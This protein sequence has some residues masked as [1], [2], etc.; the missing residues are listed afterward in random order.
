MRTR[1]NSYPLPFTSLSATATRDGETRF[2][3]TLQPTFDPDLGYHYGAAVP[4]VE[5]GDDLTLSVDVPPQIARHEGY[6]TAFFEFDDV[7][8]TA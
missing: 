8:L 4:P 3:G 2:A 5:A 1:Y 6:E 7:S